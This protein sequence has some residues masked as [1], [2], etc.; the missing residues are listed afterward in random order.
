MT[1]QQPRLAK[2]DKDVLTGLP[3]M[4]RSGDGQPDRVPWQDLDL[5]LRDPTTVP[6]E[7]EAETHDHGDTVETGCGVEVVPGGEEGVA[8]EVEEGAE[9]DGRDDVEQLSGR[10]KGCG[11]Y[12]W[13]D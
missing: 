11:R 10:I 13:F 12:A 9:E 2:V 6:E 7:H 5:S 4:F 1:L 8:V 3:L